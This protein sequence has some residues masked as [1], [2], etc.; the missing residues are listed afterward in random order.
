MLGGGRDA[1]SRIDARLSPYASGCLLCHSTWC[2]FVP[3]YV[4][5]VN[6]RIA[7]TDGGRGCPLCPLTT[8]QSAPRTSQ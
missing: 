5:F 1:S 7:V 2:S 3:A 6:K 8:E 4:C